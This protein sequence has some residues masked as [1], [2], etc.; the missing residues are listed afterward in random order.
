M[1][2]NVKCVVTWN[3]VCAAVISRDESPKSPW[4]LQADNTS[5]SKNPFWSSKTN[6]VT[7]FRGCTGKITELLHHFLLTLPEHNNQP[8]LWFS[9][10]LVLRFVA[11]HSLQSRNSRFSL[12]MNRKM[13]RDSS[14]HK[15][16]FKK[17]NLIQF[18]VIEQPN[19]NYTLC[20][21]GLNSIFCLVNW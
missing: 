16:C 12:C 10:H 6:S 15:H 14:T 19:E 18:D 8:T 1:S 11:V 21:D 20:Y 3:T 2:S 17:C 4:V 7:W 13:W 5:W 9:F